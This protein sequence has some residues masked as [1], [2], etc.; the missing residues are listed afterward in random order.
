MNAAG[1]DGSGSTTFAALVRSGR[2]IPSTP[3][4]S[5]A[6]QPHTMTNGRTLRK[7][8]AMYR[9]NFIGILKMRPML[10]SA[11]RSRRWCVQIHTHAAHSWLAIITAFR[12]LKIL[13]DASAVA[14]MSKSRLIIAHSAPKQDEIP[15]DF[16]Q[17][18]AVATV[19]DSK[20]LASI[21]SG[22]GAAA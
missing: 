11:V 10:P 16:F 21:V 14:V 4:R 2:I 12:L 6:L 1:V 9:L 18:I 17:D 19:L 22:K 8:W 15:S 7:S 3:L 5:F 20:G 13:K